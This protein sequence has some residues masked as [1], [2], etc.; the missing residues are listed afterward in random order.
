MRRTLTILLALSLCIK[1]IAAHTYVESSVLSSGNIVKLQISSTGIYMLTY[2]QIQDMGLNPS[3]VRILGY[4]GNLIEQDFTKPRIDDVPSVPFYMN[5]G[6]DNVFNSGDYI[7]FYA[8]GPVGWDWNTTS[9]IYK[10][11]RNCYADYGCYF[12][13]D[14]AGEQLLLTTQTP[15]TESTPYDIYTYTALQLH[16]LDQCN[17][18]DLNGESGGGREW[19]GESITANAKLTIPFTFAD[20]DK[21]GKLICRA[22]AAA[23]A[24]DYTSLLVNVA[25]ESGLCYFSSL[26]SVQHASATTGSC[27]ISSASPTGNSLPVKL[28][29]E[30]SLN[31]AVAYLNYIEMQ[32]PCT[33]RLR[34]DVLFIRN[35]EHIGE[36]TASRYHLLGADANTQIWNITHPA[37]ACLMSTTWEGDTLCWLGSNQEAQLFAAVRVNSTNWSSPASR[38]RIANQ[39]IHKE[40]AG[41][42]HVIVSPDEFR[43]AAERLKTAHEQYS[44]NEKWVVVSDEQVYNEFS[45]GTPDASA[46]RWMMKYMYDTAPN[47]DAKPLSLLLFGDGS[48]DN[49]QLLK[50]SPAPVLITYQAINSTVET[51]AYA[52]DDYFGWLGDKDGVSGTSWRDAIATM[53]IGVGRLPVNT[54]EEA[55]N[56]VDKIILYLSNATAGKWKQ[57]L[58]FLGDDGDHGLHISTVDLAAQSVAVTAPSYVVNKIYLDAY[59]QETSASGE[60]YPLAYNTFC[61]FLQSGVLL[62]DYAGHGSANNICSEMFLTRKQVE[63]MTNLNQGLW[64]LASCNFSHFD[65][66]STSTAEVAVL[67]P[68]GGAIGVIS[69]DRTVFATPNA[70]INNYLCQNLFYHTDPFTYPYSIGEALRR[71]KN[72]CGSNSINKLPYVL[73]GDPAIKLSHPCQYE[74]IISDMPDTFHALDLITIHGYISNGDTLSSPRRD[75]ISFDGELAVN[76][77]DKQKIVY[78]KDNDEPDASK[79]VYIPF[80]DYP[81][82][83][84]SGITEVKDGLFTITFRMPKDIRYNTDLGRITLYAKGQVENLFA[85]AMG[86]TEQFMVGGSSPLVISDNQ[87]PTIKMYLNDSSFVSGDNVNATPH[88][89]AELYDQ[90]GINTVGSGIGHDLQLIIDNSN[91]QTYIL[92]SYYTS[93]S[94]SYQRGNVNYILPE[95]SNGSHTLSFRAWDMLNNSTTQTLGFTVDN[96]MGPNIK[97]VVVYPNPVSKFGT[98]NMQIKHDRPDDLLDIEL[99]LYNTLGQKV[100][101]SYRNL[102][103]TTVS[104]DM[105]EAMLPAGTYIYQFIIQTSTQASEKHSGRIIVY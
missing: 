87:G 24:N 71:A 13:S 26:A 80:D 77:Y 45:S 93:T 63:N 18:V 66:T 70:I 78:T 33:L 47:D 99:T 30:S 42:Q 104:F 69:S 34:E 83:L 36:S 52:T 2:D 58:C 72:Q 101:S 89:F 35:T 20:A 55:E 85:E 97:S 43:S 84:F 41:K 1:L 86:H 68:H 31:S 37:S 29:Y 54:Y 91:K 51:D 81:N 98:L 7:L 57:Q 88:F 75:T 49:R 14:N 64:A 53:S 74:I 46:I 5:K 23:S 90:N 59:E 40:L 79:K 10:H 38:G 11:T 19:Y 103:D 4:G 92:N 9:R 60:S 100:W 22:D 105:S 48:F 3:K 50:T 17:L 44:P 94:N 25:G 6:K 8:N 62:M 65:Q 96:E 82:I 32:V 67:N 73:L 39:N 95:L 15:L 28:T 12:L 102:Y 21:N 56:V 27:T 61:N 76:V 16:E